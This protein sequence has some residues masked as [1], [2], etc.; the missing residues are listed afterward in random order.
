MSALI[1]VVG[2]N[3]TNQSSSAF[4]VTFYFKGCFI[5]LMWFKFLIFLIMRLFHSVR[6]QLVRVHPGTPKNKKLKNCLNI[7]TNEL[8]INHPSFTSSN[9]RVLVRYSFLLDPA[10][11]VHCAFYTWRRLSSSLFSL[12]GFCFAC[13]SPFVPAHGALCIF[14]SATF[15]FWGL[16][17]LLPF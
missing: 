9:W 5:T 17:H 6:F 15:Y 3:P 2:F 1:N 11:F 13:V 8:N 12:F 16:L 4:S 14:I 10:W 7:K